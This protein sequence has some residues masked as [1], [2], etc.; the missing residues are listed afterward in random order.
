MSELGD[1]ALTEVGTANGGYD[2]DTAS[3]DSDD[4]V[5]NAEYARLA[6][7]H[8]KEATIYR[9]G[10][11]PLE[12]EK[13]N[14]GLKENGYPGSLSIVPSKKDF[15]E[16]RAGSCAL[17]S[18]FAKL[19][20]APDTELI[21]VEFVDSLIA[22][23]GD[24]NVTDEFGQTIMHEVVRNWR[25]EVADFCFHRFVDIDKPDNYGRTPLHLASAVNYPE[26]IDWLISHGADLH[27]KTKGELQAPIHYAAKND[28]LQ[29]METLLNAGA[30]L[31]EQDFKE[32]MP[33]F[34][35]AEAGRSEACRL[36]MEKGA[37]VGI[38][39]DVGISALS[40]MVEKMPDVAKLALEQFQQIDNAIRR[41]YYYLNYLEVE[42][43]RKNRTDK[44][45]PLRQSFARS[46]LKAIVLYN[47]LTLVVHPVILRLINL[48]WKLFGK[49]NALLNLFINIFYTFIWTA[50]GVTIPRLHTHGLYTPVSKQWWRMVIEAI[51]IF[52]TFG[53]VIKQFIDYRRYKSSVKLYREWQLR[54]IE[55]DL[56]FCHPQWPEERRFLVSEK[57]LAT[58]SSTSGLID[59]WIIFEWITYFGVLSVMISRAVNII[60]KSHS[61]HRI[62]Q[63]LAA[64]ALIFI[65][66]R[67][68]KYCRAFQALG[69]FITMLGHVIDATFKF[70]FLFI[71]VFV[72][73]CCA[74]WIIFGEKAETEFY[75]FND[76]AYQ[77]FMM[78]LVADYEYSQLTTQDK[79]LAEI[80]VGSYL[81]IAGVVCLNLYIALMSETFSRVWSEA[82]ANAYMSQASQLLTAESELEDSK[83]DKMHNVLLTECSP[84]IVQ[85]S[86]EPSNEYNEKELILALMHKV[87]GMNNKFKQTVEDNKFLQDEVQALRK[88]VSQLRNYDES[89]F[90]EVL[91]IAK[92]TSLAKIK[93]AFTSVQEGIGAKVRKTLFS[94]SKQADE[95]RSNFDEDEMSLK[96]DFK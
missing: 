77:V 20:T 54:E 57:S 17:L 41:K 80:L 84:L 69:P 7:R 6:K 18:Y 28:A 37:P 45:K 63:R 96:N 55:R 30:N 65:W 3:L 33:L 95:N 16:S 13:D 46:P 74:F 72:P 88:E 51:G 61:S 12:D 71:E 78:T 31:L 75:H 81:A 21:D 48:K 68:M 49:K 11:A 60:S 4:V 83:L 62:H 56:Q 38:Y 10:P 35:A 59:P 2:D 92:D 32:R 86:S 58:T 34:V 50:I 79:L 76:L 23:G 85:E 52:M 39:N 29:A 26:M 27:R 89:K 91:E 66:V 82:T 73:Y 94:R 93:T 5:R 9:K 70:L 25:V 15:E 14:G 24:I 36:L 64:F 90:N 87:D 8:K 47:E 22:G 19:G 43:W 67:L 1:F 42:T 53:F 44:G 40:I